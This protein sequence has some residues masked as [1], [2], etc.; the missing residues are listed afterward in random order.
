PDLP[1]DFDEPE[2][3]V[4]LGDVDGDG[5][6]T[7]SDASAILRYIV[8]YVDTGINIQYGDVDSD[9]EITTSDASAILRYIVGYTDNPNIGQ[10]IEY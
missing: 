4:I 8:G 2:E 7:T 5:R 1:G 3:S 6:I 9:E 10:P